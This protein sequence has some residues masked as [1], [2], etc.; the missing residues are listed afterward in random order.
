M[1]D[2]EARFRIV[3]EVP[4]PDLW[5][6]IQSRE[7]RPRSEP[8]WRRLGVAALAVAVAAGGL[9]LVI[10]AFT[11]PEPREGLP[12]ADPRVTA[13]IPVGPFP[14]AIAA[15][16][17][18]VW[19]VVPG[20]D[21]DGGYGGT[22]ERIDPATNQ[23]VASIPVDTSDAVA[24]GAGSVW[25]TGV[26]NTVGPSGQTSDFNGVVLRI[27]PDTNRVVD[28]IPYQGGSPYDIAAD[29]TGVWVALST[30]NRSGAILHFDPT[31]GEQVAAI[32]VADVP[33]TV[34]TGEGYVWVLLGPRGLVKIDPVTDEVVATIDVN[35][36]PF[37]MAVGEGSVWVQSWLSA[38]DPGVGTGSEDRLVAV[39][40]DARTNEH[41]QPV[42]FEEGFRPVVV[43]EG[44][45]WFLGGSPSGQGL[46]IG[47]LDPTTK[48]VDA[49]AP[50]PEIELAQRNIVAFEARTVSIW[51]ANYRHSVTR[52]DLLD[53]GP[54]EMV[55]EVTVEPRIVRTIEVG[56]ATAVEA[57]WGSVWVTVPSDGEAHLL[58]I[59]PETGET[60]ET[61]RLPATPAWE[62]GG[63]G[64]EVGTTGVW[65][66]TRWDTARGP[67]EALLHVDPETSRLDRILLDDRDDAAMAADVTVFNGMAWATVVGG[68][69]GPEVVGFVLETGEITRVPLTQPYAREI[70]ASGGAIW[71][72]EHKQ[73]NG[74]VGDSVLT[75]ID[76]AAGEVVASM[77]FEGWASIAPGRDVI[78]APED[79]SLGRIDPVTV[80]V[81][82]DPIPSPGVFFGGVMEI[83]PEG[84][85]F[86]G[87]SEETGD[88][89][90]SRLN[91]STG[92]VDASVDLATGA[93]PIA[94]DVTSDTIWVVTDQGSLLQIAL[95]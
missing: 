46:T 39:R 32:P 28:R 11:A 61:I 30:A 56:R 62:L 94:M 79:N 16:E 88:A 42:V 74:G 82:G 91:P 66:A 54:D 36:M 6:D 81:V 93:S 20:D 7:P 70:F 59:D 15:G 44:G 64:I 71:V 87:Q 48:E 4:P 83:G 43:N 18:G 53:P 50:L 95:N 76:P 45:V 35:P 63:A 77:P 72:H 51:I 84:L 14:R 92:E 60:V 68:V 24:A 85:W 58:R 41:D 33:Y 73:Q 3:R 40:V 8:P 75:K 2:L 26:T 86:M 49:S 9:V 21:T 12:A 80:T 55:E 47:R 69:D 5:P 57:G 67:E 17:G 38:F 31:T 1:P 65:L 25:V 78:W 19:V 27:D 13:T 34:T 52:V 89:T 23:V 10:R 90:I 22:V 37:E 29:A